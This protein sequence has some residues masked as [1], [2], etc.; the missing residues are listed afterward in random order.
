MKIFSPSAIS[1]SPTKDHITSD[2]VTGDNNCSKT[3]KSKVKQSVTYFQH[4]LKQQTQ[5]ETT[6]WAE[7][8]KCMFTWAVHMFAN[9]W[10]AVPPSLYSKP[11]MLLSGQLSFYVCRKNVASCLFC[12]SSNSEC[13][14]FKLPSYCYS[15]DTELPKAQA[16][17]LR[18]QFI[19]SWWVFWVVPVFL[20]EFSS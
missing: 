7:G 8:C 10:P 2:L 15:A 11:C 14:C 1:W 13:I 18:R 12:T 5:R 16:A 6:E 20:T 19:R 4:G 17:Q 3:S 9:Q